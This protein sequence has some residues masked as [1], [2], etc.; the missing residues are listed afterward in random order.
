MII[1]FIDVF[2]GSILEFL[3]DCADWLFE[4]I[5]SV[6]F[7]IADSWKYIV[8]YIKCRLSYRYR[9]ILSDVATIEENWHPPKEWAL[10]NFGKKNIFLYVNYFYNSNDI[11]VGNHHYNFKNK[12][13]A[14][15]FKMVWKV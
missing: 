3:G 10:E 15:H 4:K 8:Y 6:P 13:D 9:V 11:L 14:I 5:W 7:Y 1:D 2:F 12:N